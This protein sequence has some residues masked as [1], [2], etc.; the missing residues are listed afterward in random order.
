ML[1]SKKFTQKPITHLHSLRSI[2]WSKL[3]LLYHILPNIFYSFTSF[4][5]FSSSLSENF[6]IQYLSSRI[7]DNPSIILQQIPSSVYSC[8]TCVIPNSS[9][10]KQYR[11]VFCSGKM[12][13]IKMNIYMMAR[14]RTKNNNNNSDILPSY[15]E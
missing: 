10:Q 11:L 2:D 14:I 7:A 1:P 13:N 8:N 9:E 15:L 4:T 3:F 5:F 6:N 12:V